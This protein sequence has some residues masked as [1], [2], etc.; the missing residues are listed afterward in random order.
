MPTAKLT[1]AAVQ[2][3]KAPPGERMDYFDAAF[4]GLALRVTGAVDQRPE[5]KTWTYFYR[6]QGKQ[7]R[8]TFEPPYPGLGLADAR[9]EATG[10]QLLLRTGKDPAT[11]KAQTK[12]SA[13]APDTIASVVD[14]FIKRHLEAKRRAPRYIEETRRNFGNHVLPRWGEKDIKAISRRDVTELLDAVMDEGSKVKKDGKRRIVPGGP[15]AANRTLAAIRALF[16]FALRRGIIEA[17]P[18]ALV[19][20]PGEE[21]RRDRTLSAEEIRAIWGTSSALGYPFGAFFQLALITGQRRNE[22]AR[23]RWAEID[24]EAGIWTL[25]AEATK[26]GR[27]HAVPLA[28]VAIEILKALPRKAHTA[29]RA[30]KPSPYVFTTTGG[31]PISGFSKAKPRLDDT[32]SKARGGDA[33]APWVIHDLR[34]TAATEMGRLGVSRFIIGKVLNHAD[35]SV[36][37][38]YDRHAYLQ[39]KR[40]AL[41]TWAQ[42]LDTLTRPP[43]DNVVALRQGAG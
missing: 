37:G 36:T 16:N 21:T 34:R 2:R 38:I 17:T 28:P 14:L 13:L 30:T 10:A 5:R 27:A 22:L 33:L 7:R 9:Q 8:L 1:D 20:R 35:R 3:L 19:E 23:M 41:E 11:V 18:V 6:F 15:I 29:G 4:P 40:H 24:L 42:H 31:A 12:A 26:A 39:E 25:P 43:G 32:I